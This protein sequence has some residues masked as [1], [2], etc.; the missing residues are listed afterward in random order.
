MTIC[1]LIVPF[2]ESFFNIHS[3]LVICTDY[4]KFFTLYTVS[5]LRL[6]NICYIL[7]ISL[8]VKGI[9]KIALDE[10]KYRIIPKQLSEILCYIEE[11]FLKDDSDFN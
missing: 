10:L 7:P 3:L 4:S 11:Q 5:F 9:R 6:P 1:A 2:H 8:F